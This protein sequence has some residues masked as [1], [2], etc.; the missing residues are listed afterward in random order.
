MPYQYTREP[1]TAEEA[2]RLANAWET[3]TE[4][5]I[6]WTLLDTGL[7]VGELC[8]LTSRNVL[9][10]QRQLRVKGKGGPFGK[11]TKV[12]VGRTSHRVRARREHHCALEKASPVKTRRAQ[13]IVRAVA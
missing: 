8:D 10:Q 4:R 1:L 11:E 6:V 12:R 13:D 3:P 9:W 5:L 2:D 7:R